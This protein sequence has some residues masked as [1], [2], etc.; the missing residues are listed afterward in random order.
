MF[1]RVL[2]MVSFYFP[3][4]GGVAVQRT[5]KFAK[6]L[7]AFG[8]RPIILTEDERAFAHLPQ[9]GGL[10]E[11]LPDDVLVL[12]TCNSFRAG[13]FRWLARLR[14]KWVVDFLTPVDMHYFWARA[15]Y[16]MA[17]AAVSEH[18]ISAVYT[19]SGPPCAHLVGLWLHR[20]HRVPWI[21]D[22]RDPWTQWHSYS[23]RTA[24]HAHID[25]RLER[26]ILENASIV[27]ANTEGSRRLLLSKY[28]E[29]FGDKT[30]V[31]PN[32]YDEADFACVKPEP[33]DPN[34]LRLVY[35]GSVYGTYSD[36]NNKEFPRVL[37]EALHRLRQAEG[38]HLPLEIT[39]A[40][41]FSPENQRVLTDLNLLGN[42]K[43]IGHVSHRA[44]IEMAAGADAGLLVMA[45]WPGNM[46]Q[47]KLYELIRAARPILAL[48][49]EG[50]ARR[51]LSSVGNPYVADPDDVEG[52][53]AEL[54]RLI[55]D[56]RS[57]PLASLQLEEAQFSRYDRRSLT[58][59]LVDCLSRI[60]QTD[61]ATCAVTTEG[62]R[63]GG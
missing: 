5:V 17:R 10:M 59:R 61:T 12:R 11:E 30:V 28:G 50:D 42:V 27:I 63:V 34:K 18:E 39:F 41:T 51:I 55:A 23:P 31:I 35:T 45:G 13:L 3:P 2:L 49:P 47:A 25:T 7:A 21:A 44:A 9:D 58:R 15:A 6:Y 48:V 57:G 1:H 62:G 52:V 29:R 53:L 16:R 32:G 26:K 37:F 38:D 24:I 54:R 43:V 46:V 56:W 19:T 36:P 20:T 14:L 8:W 60:V 4:C 40:G 33:R 22:F